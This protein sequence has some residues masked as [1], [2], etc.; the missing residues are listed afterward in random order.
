[1]G[2]FVVGGGARNDE[3]VGGDEWI[4]PLG[5]EVVDDDKER[6]CRGC[7]GGR[8]GGLAGEGGLLLG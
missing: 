5:V 7:C 4:S 6:E 2:L 1:M 8:G 3:V